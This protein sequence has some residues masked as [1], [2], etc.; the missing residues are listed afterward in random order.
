MVVVKVGFDEL[1]MG[2][3]SDGI[4]CSVIRLP[5]PGL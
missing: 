2:D 1:T 5:S 4:A 3:R